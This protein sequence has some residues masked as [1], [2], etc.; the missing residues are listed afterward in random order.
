MDERDR[1]QGRLTDL[2]DMFQTG[3]LGRRDFFHQ[4]Y[5]EG[6]TPASR[7]AAGCR[8]DIVLIIEVILC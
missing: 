1:M 2:A 6:L 5:Y 7:C 3:S 4:L 8:G